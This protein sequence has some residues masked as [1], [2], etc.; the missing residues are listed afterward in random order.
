M[1][2]VVTLAADAGPLGQNRRASDGRRACPGG[3]QCRDTDPGGAVARAPAAHRPRRAGRRSAAISIAQSARRFERTEG[4]RALTSAENLAGQPAGPCSALAGGACRSPTTGS[5][6]PPRVRADPVRRPRRCCWPTPTARWSSSADPA[7][8][9][10][11]ARASAD[12]T[13]L[14]G[15]SWTGLVDDR[16]RARVVVGQ[17]PVFDPT[18][19]RIV[20]VAVG[21]AGLPLGLERL[22]GVGAE[23]ADLP[24]HRQRARAR[25]LAAARPAGQAPD[26]RHGAARRSPGWSST[27]RRCC[28]ASRRAWSASTRDERVTLV[29][30]S[31]AQL[32]RPARATAS[33]RSLDDLTSTRSCATC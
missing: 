3:E 12:P 7:Q 15:R 17:V 1:V 8:V 30:D 6:P 19:G 13:W 26:A 2:I 22:A 25:R 32:L 21:R 23:P 28:T 5:R 27:A 29:N 24:R 14:R 11:A 20:G 4:R 9:G 16:S 31:A 33:G 10:T 18:Q